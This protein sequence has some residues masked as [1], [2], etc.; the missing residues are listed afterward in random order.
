MSSN[1]K[2]GI[3]RFSEA[4]SQGLSRPQ[5]KFISQ[6]IYGMLAAQSCH[7]S[8]I[9]RA[10]GEGISLKKSIDRLSRNLGAF[11]DRD[12][13]AENV[14][15][16][17]KGCLSDRSVLIIDGGDITKPCSPKMEYI[18][19]VRDGSTGGY[20]DGYHTLSV[21]ALTPEK[22]MP[23]CVYSSVHSASEPGFVSEDDEVLKALRFVGSHFSKKCIRAFDRGYDANIY[24]EHLIR[25]SEKFVIRAKKNRDVLY[26][27]DKINILELAERYKGKY[28]LA[29]KKKNGV[30]AECKV[31][32]VPISLPCRPKT[33]LNLVVCHGLGKTPM[34]LITNMKSDDDRLA[35]TVTKVYL[36][37]WRIE[38]YYAFKKQQFG[39][40]DL[41]VRS[42]N[43]IRNIDMILSIAIGY[44]GYM[45]AKGDERRVVM[46]LIHISRRIYEPP[47]F[48]FFALADAMQK[49]FSRASPGFSSLLRK[50]QKDPQL[51][52]WPVLR[53]S[54]T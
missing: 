30:R 46:E 21:T 7:L 24:Y 44:I 17:L 3:L 1:L 45:S 13:L 23:V 9:A 54:P 53:L 15:R 29:F 41:R 28:R 40:E 10:L 18:D 2:R 52:L 26:K 25:H 36:M 5:L 47:K 11:R 27:G 37:R 32:V 4:V 14:V 6:L 19:R 8:K 51:S 39:L 20:G 48:F 31:S 42:I 16:K 38:E 49:V 33:E 22:K 34:M 12:R 35:L 43:S 50:K